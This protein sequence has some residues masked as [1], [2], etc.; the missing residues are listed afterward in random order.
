[1]MISQKESNKSSTEM[2][3]VVFEE[4]K[5]EIFFFNNLQNKRF[6]VQNLLF[7]I[8]N[9]FVKSCNMTHVQVSYNMI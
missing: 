8:T 6:Y 2:P 7:C 1:M 4:F 5:I 3:C 9:E